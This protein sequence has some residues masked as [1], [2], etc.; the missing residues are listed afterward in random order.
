L[1]TQKEKKLNQRRQVRI[2][3]GREKTFER[4]SKKKE[5]AGGKEKT[6][7][8]VLKKNPFSSRMDPHLFNKKWEG[9]GKKKNGGGRQRKGTQ[10][11]GW[12]GNNQNKKSKINV[13]G[14]VGYSTKSK[15]RRSLKQLYRGTNGYREEFQVSACCQTHTDDCTG[16]EN[17]KR[18]TKKES[19]HDRR[20]NKQTRSPGGGTKRPKQN[21]VRPDP[22]TLPTLPY[23]S[24][25]IL[26]GRKKKKDEKKVS[27]ASR[28]RIKKNRANLR[29]HSVWGTIGERPRFGRQVRDTKQDNRKVEK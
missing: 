17:Q 14:R 27:L 21:K 20:Q 9:G 19:A 12:G 11:L 23:A 1:I 26:G 16:G 4:T 10:H 18:K 28:R 13:E 25:K 24:A 7:V 3:V 15:D 5:N 29:Q 2:G 6:T 8:S 22:K